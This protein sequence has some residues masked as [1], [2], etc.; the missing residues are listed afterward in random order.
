[1]KIPR[2]ASLNVLFVLIGTAAVAIAA[3]PQATDVSARVRSWEQHVRMEQESPFGELQWRAVGPQ[4]AGARVEA[5][6]V[7]PGNHG[8][9]YVGIGSGN[10]WKTTNN[11][12][13]WTPIFEHESA[14][15]IGDVAVSASNPDVVWVGTGET[16]PRHSG[17]SFSGT[18]VFK[19]TDAGE[20]WQNMGLQDTHHIGKV[21]IDPDNPD[22]V[23]VAAIGHFGSPNGERGVFRTEDGGQTWEHTL[24][25]SQKTGAVEMAMDPSDSSILYAATW[26]AVSGTADEGGPESRIYKSTDTGRTWTMLEN[27][28]PGG[29]LGRIGLDVAPSNPNVVYAF[30]DNR[31]PP[32]PAEQPAA[33]PAG[34]RGGRGSRGARGGRGNNREIIGGEIYRSDDKGET[35]YKANEEDTYPF[36]GVY[37]WKFTDIRV[38]PEN[39]DEIF[40]LG[41]RAYHSVDGGK[42]FEQIGETI[43]RLHDTRG[44]VMHLD[45]HEI[46]IDPLNA[47]RIL[48][49]NDGGLYESHDRGRTWLHI[50]NIPAAEFYSVS[51]DMEV[52]YNIFGGTQDNAALYGPSDADAADHTDD[53][54]ENVY[55]D[56]WTGGDS[57]DT[58]RDPTDSDIVYYEHQHGA[59]LR[60]DIAP[61]GDVQSGGDSAENI[62]AR[63]PEGEPGWRFSWYT[64]I[65]IS[66]H[67]P[68]TLIVGANYVLRSRNRGDD[69]ET[70][71]PDLSDE[72][73]GVRA[74]V[75]FGTITMLSESRL[76]PGVLYAGTEAGKIWL[77]SDDGANW[78]RISNGLPQKWVSRV[79]A[80]GH[81]LQRVYASFTG[82]REDDFNAY[83]F[84]SHDFGA[85]WASISDGLPAE[86]I[87]V[88]AEDPT[89]EDIL[90]VGT[91]L[92]VYVSLDRGRTWNSLSA[93]LPTTPVH[94]LEVHPRDAEIVI[95]THG[96][97]VWILNIE[98]VREQAMR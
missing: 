63:A 54:W 72:G 34:G 74:V 65:I 51:L 78:E 86:S 46:W 47:D 5:I 18:G 80:S 82:Y 98:E 45:H 55:L 87:N 15:A 79:L 30:I 14:F 91:D 43:I 83:L 32:P 62:R 4:Q 39:E 3:T 93:T 12:V 70:M 37:G 22:V 73:G 56:R 49:G 64:P 8:T 36:F 53:R 96:R 25:I 38:S 28:L 92:G 67:D 9:I 58:L 94:D 90:Y 48:L 44:L 68:R 2:R 71:S 7:P 57:F 35:W 52:P 97:S 21:L 84:V 11:G 88:I 33:Q 6:A 69:W 61:G 23:H 27:G 26:Q 95:G 89:N 19:S 17:Y 40:A 1:M 29:S 60:M 75:P 13:T 50:N 59:M 10:L 20:S 76:L 16:Q 24:S 85:S 41:N 77:T 42:T 81:H 31:N 66:H